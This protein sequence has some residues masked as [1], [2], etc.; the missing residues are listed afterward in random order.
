ML[1]NY[2]VT[3]QEAILLDL[4]RV[5]SHHGARLATPI[6]TIQKLYSDYDL[7]IDPFDS[8][9]FTPSR[10]KGNHSVP[11]IDEGEK[12]AATW[13]PSS[14]VKSQ[15]KLKSSS[16]AKPQNVGSD[17]SVQK[18]SKSRSAPQ[19]FSASNGTSPSKKD[20]EK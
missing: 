11:F 9:I 5:I 1:D 6:R 20:E 7:E 16:Q 2:H 17:N 13:T 3:K 18:A 10:A 8:T 15:D 14:S 12:I 4:L 19:T